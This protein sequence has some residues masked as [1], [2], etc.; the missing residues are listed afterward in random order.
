MLV[1]GGLHEVNTDRHTWSSTLPPKPLI[2]PEVEG[3]RARMVVHS[4]TKN[5]GRLR[6][7]GPLVKL[8]QEKQGLRSGCCGVYG[9]TR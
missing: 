8:Q 7:R 3:N 6:R 9:E 2:S 4:N 5:T 1:G